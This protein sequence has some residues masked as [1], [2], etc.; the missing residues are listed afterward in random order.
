M[1]RKYYGD[2]VIG[3]GGDVKAVIMEWSREGRQWRLSRHLWQ[4]RESVDA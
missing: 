1:S 3:V 4:P 2:F